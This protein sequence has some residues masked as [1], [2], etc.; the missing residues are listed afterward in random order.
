MN[1]YCKDGINYL[2]PLIDSFQSRN[3]LNSCHKWKTTFHW[4]PFFQY[5]CELMDFLQIQNIFQPTVSI[6]LFMLEFSQLEP[7]SPFNVVPVFFCVVV[8]LVLTQP[9]Q[10]WKAFLLF[11]TTLYSR[12][13]CTFLL[14]CWIISPRS[15]CSLY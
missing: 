11:D 13:T 9:H 14:R 12:L 5:Y 7:W 15:P 4:F 8:V 2:F 10:S 3:W 1:A 6:I